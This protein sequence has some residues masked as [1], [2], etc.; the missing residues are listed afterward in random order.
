[1]Q[2]FREEEYTRQSRVA[3]KIGTRPWPI[4]G[5]SAC[6]V[7]LWREGRKRKRVN[8]ASHFFRE[9]RVDATLPRHTIF[10]GEGRRNDLDM[11]MG[12]ALRPCANMAGVPVGLIADG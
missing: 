7:F 6:G 10:P 1:M 11:K 2:S 3:A 8:R 12:F 4:M 9:E 5:K